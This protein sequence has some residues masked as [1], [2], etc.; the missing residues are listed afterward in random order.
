MRRPLAWAC[1]VIVILIYIAVG[2]GILP[3][4][5][6]VMLPEDGSSISITGRAQN[7]TDK[8]IVIKTEN[9]GTFMAYMSEIPD[10]LKLGEALTLRG[11]ISHF[12]HAMNPGSFDALDYYTSKDIDARLWDSRIISREG[13]EYFI[14]EHLRRFRQSLET[15]LY[16]ICPEK[17]ASILCDLLLGDKEG[18]DEE[19]DEL[20]KNSGIAH[21]L[22]ISG[23]HI[24]ILGM[25]LFS[26]LR[27]MRM[28][29]VP[30]AMCAMCVLALYG[31]MTGLSISAVRAIGT[32]A[33]RM[34]AYPAK[35]TADPLT[36]LMLMAAITLIIHP[37]YAMQAGFM[38]SYGAALGIHTF[39][40]SFVTLMDRH[41][42]KEIFYERDG[43]KKRTKKFLQKAGRA[44]K[45]AFISSLGIILFTLPI[46][47]YFFY[48]VSV[49]SVFL[50]LLILPCMSLLVFSAMVSLIPGLGIVASISCFLLEIFERLCR[51][52]ETL[53][54]HTW[55][56]GKPGKGAIVLYYLIIAGITVA[57]KIPLVS[58]PILKRIKLF[59]KGSSSYLITPL[60]TAITCIIMLI[61]INFPLPSR[62]TSTQLYVGQG[63]CNV[64]ITDT[65]EV[66]IFDGGSS[67]EKS[68][69]EYTIMPFLRYNGLP[70]IDGIFLSHS[71]EDHINGILELIEN[72]EKWGLEIRDVYITPQMRADNMENTERLLATCTNAGIPVT[73]ITA[74]DSWGS[75]D[76]HFQCLHPA[77]D[78]VPEDPNSGSMVIL[79]EFTPGALRNQSHNHTILIPGDVQGTGEEALTE[80]IEDTLSGNRLDIYITAHHGSSGTTTSDFLEAARPRL[81]INSAGLNNRY[82]HPNA[83]T[84]ERFEASGCAWLTLYETGAVTLD[85][86]GSE[87]KVSTFLS[88]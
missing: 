72:S 18:I 47:L 70:E 23:L 31:I 34:L 48:R 43:I 77:R 32:F 81:A 5:N 49:Y 30:A 14:R 37:V 45:S 40:P 59:S 53:P 71:D 44:V 50:N 67:S 65:G 4:G 20:Y 68:V 38:L 56:P 21:I 35:R 12:S 80:V 85:F 3:F 9:S 28:K 61:I 46:Q 2:C 7:I 36:S 13:G 10:D 63:N 75:G 42:E 24:S 1:T 41:I 88:Y 52:S 51:L 22:S 39:L 15:R 25:G 83:A 26:L 6:K 76:T 60:L 87:I 29:Q 58:N 27:K 69:G 11:R 16:T 78:Y 57:P 19:T 62:E 66:Y 8:Y 33:I 55:N 54:F 64:L 86:S 73:D 17:E 82:G 74:G 79:A 84:L